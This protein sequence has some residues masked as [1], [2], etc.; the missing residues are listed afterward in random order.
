[1]RDDL[2]YFIAILDHV[3]VEAQYSLGLQAA[4]VALMWALEEP[5]APMTGA[6]KAIGEFAGNMRA[7]L[8]ELGIDVGLT[9]DHKEYHT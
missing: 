7:N 2:L 8:K 3:G 4:T 5:G 6:M 9:P 1:M